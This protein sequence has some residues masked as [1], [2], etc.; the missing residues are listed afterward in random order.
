MSTDIEY[1]SA[2]E[3]SAGFAAGS[4]SP[5]AATAAALAAIDAQ[6]GALNAFRLVDAEAARA[7]AAES[8]RRWQAKSSLSPLDGVP[9]SIKDLLLTKG[10]PTLRGSKL[11]DPEQAWDEDAPGVARLREA[12]AVLLGKTNTAEF[13]W[14]G[15]TDSP[16]AGITR[17]PWNL[18]LTPGGS[19]GGASAAL[20]AGMGALALCTDGG[21]S[22]RNPAGFTN[23]C[24]LKPSFGRVPA[25]P[26]NPI[27]TLANVGP[28]A[29]SVSDLAL[30]LNVISRPDTRD[31]LSLPYDNADYL[32]ALESG[33][34]GLNIGF[35]A[36]LGFA[37]VDGEIVGLIA[38]AAQVFGDLGARVTEV[39]PP[40]GDCTPVFDTH[41]HVGVASAFEGLPDD[42]LK[43]LD[44][45]LDYFVIEGRKVTLMEYVA[46]QN[47]RTALGQAMRGFHQKY[48]LLIL[49]TTAMPAFPVERR[50]PPGIGEDD[51]AAWS[52]FSYPFNLTM[53][54][55]LSLP[56]GFNSAGLPVGLQIVGAMHQDALVLRA[57]RAFEQATGHGTRRPPIN[58][59]Q[60]C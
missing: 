58:L 6:D 54:P 26:P 45:G 55:A 19:S 29:R 40:L 23:L 8:E 59:P 46:A 36:N 7:A 12:G 5:V 10:W 35:S 3:L 41:W 27:G 39:D 44:P 28:M 34:D 20:A 60:H 49:P 15:A 16:L 1:L 30:M 57:G 22:I 25:Y 2:T 50:A 43:L 32:A 52:P 13:G 37:T 21:G 47:A 33:V 38:A 53:Q 42:K 51:W 11:V 9:V 17:N 4:I 31:W 24:G 18:D 56:A 14:K 48:D